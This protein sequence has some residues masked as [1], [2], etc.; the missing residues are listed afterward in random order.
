[1]EIISDNYFQ[2]EQEIITDIQKYDF[3][4]LYLKKIGIARCSLHFLDSPSEIYLNH[5]ILAEKFRIIRFGLFPLSRKVDSKDENK[6][7]YEANYIIYM[8]PQEKKS[9]TVR[10]TV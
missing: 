1:M 6:I 9:I 5:K 10:A 2:K 4:N 8:I 7:A 3:L